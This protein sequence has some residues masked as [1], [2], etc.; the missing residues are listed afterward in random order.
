VIHKQRVGLHRKVR[1][2]LLALVAAV[3]LGG[4]SVAP[5]LANGP[6]L[7]QLDTRAWTCFVPPTVPAW[8]VCYNSGLGRP[9][10]GNPEP[11]PSYTF[12][13]FSSSSGEFLFTGHLVRADLYENQPCGP[14]GGPYV[15]RA[16]I[17]YFECVHT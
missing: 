15:F 11:P 10:L 9:I 3:L 1:G 17:G 6:S 5:A 12:L 16:L 14:S 4:A 8:V 7:G 2:A 13:A